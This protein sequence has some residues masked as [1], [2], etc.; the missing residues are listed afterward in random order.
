MYL[1]SEIPVWENVLDHVQDALTKSVHT[2]LQ[3]TNRSM[4]FAV[5]T[6]EPL[7]RMKTNGSVPAWVILLE[8]R[9]S[10]LC[11]GLELIPVVLISLIAF[12]NLQEAV[13]FAFASD[14]DKLNSDF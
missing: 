8:R 4:A 6:Q 13:L 7:K 12:K 10:L 14:V 3:W 5:F 9:I 1:A 2:Y 11:C